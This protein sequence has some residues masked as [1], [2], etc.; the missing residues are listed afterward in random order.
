MNANER[1]QSSARAV[2][3]LYEDAWGALGGRLLGF[4]PSIVRVCVFILTPMTSNVRPPS[5]TLTERSL[6]VLPNTLRVC[7]TLAITVNDRVT[8]G[9]ILKIIENAGD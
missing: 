2:H 5:R 3:G 7:H 9:Q 1:W 4:S 6:G 8:H